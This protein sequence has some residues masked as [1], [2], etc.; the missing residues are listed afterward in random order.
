MLGRLVEEKD[1]E[2]KDR[3]RQKPGRGQWRTVGGERERERKKKNAEERSN[4]MEFFRPQ[5]GRVHKQDGPRRMSEE[6]RLTRMSRT[7]RN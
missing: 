2:V 1:R 3:R 7:L 4:D 5:E 6:G